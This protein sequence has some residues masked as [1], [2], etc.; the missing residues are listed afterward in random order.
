[1]GVRI[2][3]SPSIGHLLDGLFHCWRQSIDASPSR[4]HRHIEPV[5][6]PRRR[7][8]TRKS[9]GV[10]AASASFD[11]LLPLLLSKDRRHRRLTSATME[12]GFRRRWYLLQMEFHLKAPVSAPRAECSA[13]RAPFVG[14]FRIKSRTGGWFGLVCSP[15]RL[16]LDLS[17]FFSHCV[18]V[19]LRSLCTHKISYILPCVI[20]LLLFLP[21]AISRRTKTPPKLS[22]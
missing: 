19:S 17:V 11:C 8:S 16:I 6:S 4:K 9:L 22:R 14:T 18:Y 1:M 3:P 13:L 15:L 21:R 7:A 20:V 5:F 12:D 10:W 2:Q